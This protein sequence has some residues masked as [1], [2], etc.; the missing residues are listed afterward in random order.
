MKYLL[1]IALLMACQFNYSQKISNEFFVFESA[2]SNDAVYNSFEKKAKLIKA[3]G[4]NG[5][6]ISELDHF[7][8]KLKAILN[9]GFKP[10]SLYT[11]LNLDEPELDP[12][13]IDAIKMLKGS[14][15]IICPYIIKKNGVSLHSRDKEVD[16]IAIQLL[17][18]LAD[19][20]DES[21]LQVAIYPHVNFYVERTDHAAWIAKKANK[22]NL[23]LT[24]NLCHWLATT[25]MDERNTL[26]NK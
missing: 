12:R 3:S 24:F 22:N 26:K 2:L 6:E 11:K 5:I 14:G 7:N 17:R 23:G 25:N 15:S 21:G 16:K 18:K 19:L 13:L 1:L 4:F 20:A 10:S 8:E 9:L